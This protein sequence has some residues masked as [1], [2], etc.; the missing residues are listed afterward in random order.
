MFK[1]SKNIFLQCLFFVL[2]W[3][4]ALFT[5][6][7][8]DLIYYNPLIELSDIIPNFFFIFFITLLF[9]SPLFSVIL[10][11]II[12][13]AGVALYFFTRQNL[14]IAQITNIPELVF[15]YIPY[16]FIIIILS[17]FIIYFLF[18]ISVKLNFILQKLKPRIFQIAMCA[19]L[20]RDL[21]RGPVFC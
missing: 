19:I 18:K 16:S 12:Y 5:L 9:S 6:Y 14:T 15:T 11:F 7:L 21:V 1:F 17:F 2:I 10:L 13:I 3:Q 4:L 8:I 20:F